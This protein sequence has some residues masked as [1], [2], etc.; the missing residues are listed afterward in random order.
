MR[1]AGVILAGA[2][3]LFV[4]PY[5]S[6]LT[7]TALAQGSIEPGGPASDSGPAARAGKASTSKPTRKKPARKSRAANSGNVAA[8]PPQP[9][10]PEWTATNGVDALANELGAMLNSRTRNGEWG[11]IVVSLTRGDTL[12]KSNADAMMQPASTMKLYTAA[13]ALERFGPN[14]EYKT[15][16][17]R[18]AQPSSDG[19]L[20]GSLYLFGD[21]DPSLC[22]RFWGD[23]SPMDSLARQIAASGIKRIRGDIV[24]DA[25]AFDDQLVPDGWKSRYLGAAYAARV[26]ALSLNEN[27]VW[28]VVQPNGRTAAVSLDPP[29]TTIPVQ[30]SVRVV[31]GR[32]GRISASRRPDGGISVRGTIGERSGPLRYSLVVED[33]ATFTTGALRAALEKVG[34]TVDGKVA[35]GVTPPHATQIASVSS[36]PLAEIVAEMNRES[37]NLYAELLFRG[38]ARSSSTGQVGSA[39]A[40]LSTLRSFLADKVGVRPIEVS[41]A[42]GSGLSVLDRVTPRSMVQLLGYAHAASWGPTFHAS[43]PLEG[44]SGTLRN[45]ARHTPARG[46]LHAKTGTTNTVASLGGYV[47]AKNGEVLAFSFIYNGGDRWN[48][49][50]TMDQMGATMAEWVR[51]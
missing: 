11:A 39:Q 15:T 3:A 31:N 29:T 6:I 25:S 9:A 41:A 8:A 30:S 40:A 12:F 36:P 44:E 37:I 13:I 35:L 42:D 17:L 50:V 7:G 47:T 19:V 45:R 38:A 26:S 16:I 5:P 20:S 34:V 27:I 33:P 18:D 14:H 28:V 2:L 46:N 10:A 22:P 43:L 51:D 48:A 21:G 32:S 23:A 49:K 1:R 4:A 24:G